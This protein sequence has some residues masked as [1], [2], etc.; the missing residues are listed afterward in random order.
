[1]I[2]HK[3][4]GSDL[5]SHLKYRAHFFLDISRQ[6]VLKLVPPDENHYFKL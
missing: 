3:E 1:M 4:G 5:E 6:V 2:S